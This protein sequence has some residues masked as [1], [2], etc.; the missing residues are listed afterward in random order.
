MADILTAF[1]HQGIKLAVVTTDNEV[2]TRQC[3]QR[4][5]IEELF[6]VIY[7]DDG[8]TPTKPNPFCVHDFCQ[9]VGIEK[10][11]VVMVGD[12]M[13]D[14]RF[15]QNAGIKVVSLAQSEGNRDILAPHA[16]VVIPSLSHLA[17]VLA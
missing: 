7:T 5:G 12:T 9:K 8:V 2:I 4:L 15:A 14:V 16:D 6:D 17:E 3:L 13:T 10:E 1:K 11:Y